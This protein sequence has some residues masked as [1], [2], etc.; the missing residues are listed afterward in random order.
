LKD[1]RRTITGIAFYEQ[2]ETPGLGAQIT[3][4]TFTSQF[5]DKILAQGDKPLNIRPPGAPLG[6][7]DV[8]AVTGATQTSTRLEKILNDSLTQWYAKLAEIEGAS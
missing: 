7:S 4:I 5:R 3:T 1:D 6:E 8:H 2:N